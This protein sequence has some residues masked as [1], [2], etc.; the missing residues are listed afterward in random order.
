MGV[1][2]SGRKQS[3]G[4]GAG[5]LDS[6]PA[7]VQGGPGHNELGDATGEGPIDDLAPIGVITVMRQIDADIDKGHERASLHS[8]A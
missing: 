5:Q 6:R 8:A 3:P 7:R 4:I 1:D 2:A